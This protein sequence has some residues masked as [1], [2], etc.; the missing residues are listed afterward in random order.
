MLYD[1]QH[2]DSDREHVG[3]IH[4]FLPDSEYL[5]PVA[6]QVEGGV[7]SA[8]PIQREFKAANKRPV[9]TLLPGRSNHGVYL[10]QI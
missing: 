6:E 2:F 9:S 8:N 1:L 5:Y 3:F 10:R 7:C 4:S